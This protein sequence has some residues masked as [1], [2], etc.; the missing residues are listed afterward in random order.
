MSTLIR[1][2]VTVGFVPTTDIAVHVGAPV[3]LSE[4]NGGQ[5]TRSF[6]IV[7]RGQPKPKVTPARALLTKVGPKAFRAKDFH[8]VTAD[9]AVNDFADHLDWLVHRHVKKTYKD[10][11]LADK[12][13][14]EFGFINKKSEMDA[15]CRV[16]LLVAAT[17]FRKLMVNMRAGT[18]LISQR[19]LDR[20][21]NFIVSYLFGI[22]DIAEYLERQGDSAYE[23]FWGHRST[24]IQTFRL[25]IASQ[26]LT[27]QTGEPNG[28]RIEHTVAQMAGIFTM[29]QAMEAKFQRLIGISLL[30][31]NG[32]TPRLKHDFHYEF[33][34]S[35]HQYFDFKTADFQLLKQIYKWC[36]QI[37]H[38]V[39][40]PP[41]WCSAFALEKAAGLFQSIN[42]GPGKAWSINNNVQIS[43]LSEMQADFAAYF[44]RNYHHGFWS[45]NLTELEAEVI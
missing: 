19:M 41:P 26:N 39:Y 11:Y 43:N 25:F 15:Y 12:C 22:K 33:I 9:R 2:R 36:S 24:G 21:A 17:Y 38:G 23:M 16:N 37:V 7:A 34:N 28:Y 8:A 45:I 35:H 30:D 42:H 31:K 27:F 44:G 32:A 13:L 4:G 20:H 1:L 10:S 14:G 18:P 3:V 29:R 5:T 40:E 6:T